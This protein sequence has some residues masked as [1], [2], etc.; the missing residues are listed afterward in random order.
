MPTTP[1]RPTNLQLPFANA[2]LKNTIPV[3]TAAG[4]LASYTEGFPAVTMQP[5]ASGGLPPYGKDFNGLLFDITSHTLWLNAGG[6]Y[7]FDAA[8]STAMGGYP[9]GMVLQ[10]D[11]GTASY[12]SAIDNNT[13]DF[14]STP[15][16]IGVSW[17]AYSGK[18]YA[19]TTVN[20]TG[21]VTVLTAT[22]AGADQITVAGVLVSN[23]TI[24]LPATTRGEWL[25]VNAT[26]GNYTVSAI[27]AGGTGVQVTQGGADKVYS[28]GTNTAYSSASAI[29]Q[30]ANDNSNR[31]ATTAY[32]DRA[33][34]QI[35]GYY[36]DTGVVVN[37]YELTQIPALLT[38]YPNGLSLR[39]RTTRANTGPTTLNA[40]SQGAVP[41]TREDGTP[42]EA[43]DISVG[44][45]TAVTYDS[46]VGG[47]LINEIVP[48]QLGDIAP[49]DMGDGLRSNGAGKVE[50]TQGNNALYMLGYL[51]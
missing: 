28:D 25:I 21:G 12:I 14:N 39:F 4:A 10:N 29:T 26:S 9:K 1:V 42:V 20:T 22:Q 36:Q 6:Q 46:V 2:G 45:I 41:M 44:S 32:A 16:A 38:P 40:G 35:G 13:T 43:G 24:T 5:V 23:V 47:F 18:A 17:L 3:A 8:L 48:S 33:V 7:R 27:T 11:D 51:M 19:N 30:A 37:A 34:A 15:A 49:L 50:V 31:H